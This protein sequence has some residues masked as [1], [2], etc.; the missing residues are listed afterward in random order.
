LAC[1]LLAIQKIPA[2]IVDDR[3]AETEKVQQFLVENVARLRL[4]ATDRALLIAHARRQGE[5]TTQVAKRFGVSPATVRRLE[6]QLD[7]ASTR[8]VAALRA[9]D[10]NLALHAVIAKHVPAKERA[11]VIQ[12]IAPHRIWA[13]EMD[14]LLTALDWHA[15]AELGPTYRG[16]RFALLE[17]SCQT[18]ASLP[19]AQP[20][21]RIGQLALQMP[22]R[23]PSGTTQAAEGAR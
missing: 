3:Y 17:W 22:L 6:A 9:G 4:G 10:L 20:W 16:Q 5:E 13:S 14:S 23:L 19:R 11:E 7:G 21:E 12:R 8:E 1:R 2:L 18:L 15:L